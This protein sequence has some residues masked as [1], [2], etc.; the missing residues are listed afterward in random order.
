MNTKNEIK[1]GRSFQKFQTT[2]VEEK[3]CI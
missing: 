2:Y 3:L 1:G